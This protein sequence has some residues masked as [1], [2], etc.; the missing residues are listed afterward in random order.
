[1]KAKSGNPSPIA[2]RFG[3]LLAGNR[4]I[5]GLS[6]E[7]LGR[8]VKIHRTEVSLLERGQRVPR[9]DTVIRLA[10]GLEI[11]PGRPDRGHRVAAWP[12]EFRRGVPR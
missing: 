5:A 3:I 12:E 11:E 6:Q 10:A 7:E 4:R 9:L 8:F 1:V 2:L